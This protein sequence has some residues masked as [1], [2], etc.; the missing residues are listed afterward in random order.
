MSSQVDLVGIITQVDL[1][2]MTNIRIVLDYKDP[3]TRGHATGPITVKRLTG[4]NGL[5][6]E[7]LQADC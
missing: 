6:H 1:E 4:R 2:Q 5:R 7:T 3:L